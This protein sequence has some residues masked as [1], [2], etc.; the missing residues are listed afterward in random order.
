LGDGG[1]VE[2]GRRKGRE[3]KGLRWGEAWGERCPGE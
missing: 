1:R 2:R 3:G